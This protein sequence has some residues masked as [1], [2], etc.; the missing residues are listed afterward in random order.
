MQT[1]YPGSTPA[2]GPPPQTVYCLSVDL[3]ASTEMALSLRSWEA[4]RFNAALIQQIEPH[5]KALRLYDAVLKFTGDG[6]LVMSAT[7]VSQLCC[8]ALIFRGAFRHEMAKLSGLSLEKIPRIKASL[9]SGRDCEVNTPSGHKDYVGDSVRRAVRASGLCKDDEILVSTSV[10]E[11]IL[12]DFEVEQDNVSAQ[13]PHPKKWEEDIALH[14]LAG[15]KA[16]LKDGG[17]TP[18]EFVYTLGK[19]GKSEEAIAAALSV[20]E[21]FEIVPDTRPVAEW[22]PGQPRE[23]KVATPLPA[24]SPA[25]RPPFAAMEWN[26]VLDSLPDYAAARALVDAMIR[27]HI[28]RDVATW[29]ILIK[30]APGAVQAGRALQNMAEDGIAPDVVTFA[31]LLNKAADFAQGEAVLARM[32]EAKVDPDVVTFNTLL[33]K[34]ADFAQG[35]AVLARMKEAKVDPDVVTYSIL[36]SKNC[37]NGSARKILEW[38]YTQRYHPSGPLD[39]LITSFRRCGCTEEALEVALQHPP[40]ADEVVSRG[41]QGKVRES[42]DVR[43]QPSDGRFCTRSVVSSHRRH[44]ISKTSF[45]SSAGV[46]TTPEAKTNH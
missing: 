16:E 5:L 22:S 11:W 2:D 1:E 8:L 14:V 34:A 9:C 39:A 32:K 20:K 38:F 31:T 46:C 27:K 19:I 3:V 7:A 6:W 13:R 25:P 28:A 40:K 24:K 15:L 36:F 41:S 44:R 30:K 21:R 29:N 4:D 35:E 23:R 26:R 37:S 17:S 18:A 10:R 33:D 12:H 42:E 43:C 45:E